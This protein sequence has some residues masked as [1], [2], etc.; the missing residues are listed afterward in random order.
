MDLFS[1]SSE[2]LDFRPFNEKDFDKLFSVLGNEEV[3]EYLPGDKVYTK[4]QVERVLNYFIKTFV[5]EKKNLHYA[6]YLKNTEEFIGYCGCSYIKEY[7]CDEIE[8]FLKPEYFG[9]GYASEM[10]FMMKRV[11][12]ELDLETIVGLADVDNEPSNK[13]LLKIGY[14]F[15]KVVEHWGSTLNLYR[16]NL[17]G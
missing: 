11:A 2:R 1:L 6:S 10:A 3:C 16:M 5:P 15:D 17:K 7:E 12:G 9:K 13:I 4:E 14:K 8:Y